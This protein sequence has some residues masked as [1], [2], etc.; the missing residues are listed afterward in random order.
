[1]EK[2]KENE[3]KMEMEKE[4][5]NEKEL[6]KEKDICLQ[7]GADDEW[8][9]GLAESQGEERGQYQHCGEAAC[10]GG[11]VTGTFLHFPTID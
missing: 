8:I 9:E 10:G 2:E 6:E 1:M 3:M 5:E 7:T 11:S 4:K